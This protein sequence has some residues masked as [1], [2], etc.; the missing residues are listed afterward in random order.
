MDGLEAT[1]LIRG[2]IDM[3]H[4]P[5]V[6]LTREM[7]ANIGNECDEIG[8]DDLFQKPRKTNVLDRIVNKY[9]ASCSQD[10]VKQ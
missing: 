6:A 10:G 2:K 4:L 7:S 1:N 5:V 9:K 8:F 3:K